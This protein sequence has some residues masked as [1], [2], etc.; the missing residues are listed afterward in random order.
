MSLTPDELGK[1]IKEASERKSQIS[2]DNKHTLD[3]DRSKSSMGK[4]L[5]AG[6]DLVAAILV[7]LFIGYWI[8]KLL[9]IAPFGM[10]IMLFLGFIAGFLNIYRAQTG[11]DYT[12]GFKDI[13]KDKK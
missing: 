7:G 5:R 10:I 12:I 13:N 6:T 3:G 11:K 1:K 8:D 4:A 2:D 9:G